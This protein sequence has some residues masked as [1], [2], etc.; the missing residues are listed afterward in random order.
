MGSYLNIIITRVL[1]LSP[2]NVRLMINDLYNQK[3]NL[4]YLFFFSLLAIILKST[5][6][7]ILFHLKV[8]D[9]LKQF[10]S[11]PTCSIFFISILV[12]SLYNITVEYLL[13]QDLKYSLIGTLYCFTTFLIYKFSYCNSITLIGSLTINTTKIYY[14]DIFVTSICLNLLIFKPYK[15]LKI[16]N[17]HDQLLEDYFDPKKHID[18]LNRKKIANTISSTIENTRTTKAFAISVVGDWGNGKTTFVEFITTELKKNE[19]NIIIEF[20]PWKTSNNNQLITEF[21]S[22]MIEEVSKFDKNL[23]KSLIS[24]SNKLTIKDNF[25]FESIYSLI[26]FS[27][28]NT[29][30]KFYSDIN[31]EI[32]NSG[33]RFIICI[34]DLDRLSGNEVLDVLKIIRNTSNFNN[35]F[36]IVGL[37]SSY[38]KEVLKKSN[39]IAFEE[40][41]TQKIFQLEFVLPPINQNNLI[42]IIEIKIEETD[43]F[44]DNKGAIIELI[45]EINNP[46]NVPELLLSEE[47]MPNKE[48]ILENPRDV[49]RFLNSFILA[50]KLI[51]DFVNLRDLITIELLKNKFVEIYI[52]LSNSPSFFATSNPDQHGNKKVI[53]KEERLKKVLEK[54]PHLV[55]QEDLIFN[56]FQR[57]TIGY[58]IENPIINSLIYESNHRMYFNYLTEGELSNRDMET[59]WD[60]DFE[61][62]KARIQL[63]NQE[64]RTK[65]LLT[66][67]LD[68]KDFIGNDDFLNFLSLLLHLIENNEGLL[69][70]FVRCVSTPSLINV[71][72]NKDDFKQRLKS[73]LNSENFKDIIRSGICYNLIRSIVKKTNEILNEDDK[74]HFLDININILVGHVKKSNRLDYKSM[75]LYYNNIVT[76]END[77]IILNELASEVFIEFVSRNFS[78]Y[79]KI[80]LRP[81]TIPSNGFYNFDPFMNQLFKPLDINSYDAFEVLLKEYNVDLDLKKFI[82]QIFDRF[83]ENKYNPIKL[84]D[85]EIEKLNKYQADYK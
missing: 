48:Y 20:N 23:K 21:F 54:Y 65:N 2:Q 33:K 39:S 36:F 61:M 50:Y 1:L 37:D 85:I 78:D 3:N 46:Y 11:S 4:I 14:S 7:E 59:F 53:V 84:S 45:K 55:S 43:T 72:L 67:I 42:K 40:K 18:L 73:L 76:I 29:I 52:E 60:L 41:Y 15:R 75:N 64:Q 79:L 66:Y 38:I 56:L 47:R 80:T 71:T 83:K 74:Q 81:Y 35:L 77:T 70:D 19:Q 12:L 44:K 34:D 31:D 69:Y 6:I 13:K 49:I 68:K 82:K 8:F 32:L 63:W 26:N 58:D 30:E 22:Q 27:N 24:Y 57:S 16:K 10:D 9:F 25:L 51:G 5:I 62:Q 17:K 28:K